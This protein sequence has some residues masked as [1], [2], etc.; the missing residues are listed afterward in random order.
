M[1]ALAGNHEPRT[2]HSGEQKKKNLEL[3]TAGR[4]TGATASAA[5]CP[6]IEVVKRRKPTKKKKQVILQRNLYNHNKTTPMQTLPSSSPS[7]S[8]C[9]NS[10]QEVS[11]CAITLIKQFKMYY[12][13]EN[14][15]NFSPSP[16]EHK[17]TV[18]HNLADIQGAI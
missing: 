14:M 5:V 17:N 12:F 13:L 16:A 8:P 4:L 18:L 1:S 6:G 3:G 7:S 9:L 2:F 10:T 15:F 11:A